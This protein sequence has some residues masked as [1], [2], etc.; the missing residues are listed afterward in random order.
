MYTI[1][2]KTNPSDYLLKSLNNIGF[3]FITHA[4][5]KQYPENT[6]DQISLQNT[7]VARSRDEKGEG[8]E[9]KLANY[10][11]VMLITNF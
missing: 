5:D 4:L 10:S 9:Q 3:E 6:E 2:I 1:Y 11:Q 7:V 8:K